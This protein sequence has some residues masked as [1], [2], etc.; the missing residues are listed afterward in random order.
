MTPRENTTLS[1]LYIWQNRGFFMG[2]LPDISEHR[3]GSAALCAVVATCLAK[4]KDD[5][6]ASAAELGHALA[7]L[8]LALGASGPGTQHGHGLAAEARH[9]VEEA[10]VVLQRHPSLAQRPARRELLVEAAAP[11]A[12][13]AL[14]PPFRLVLFAPPRHRRRP[15]AERR[16]RGARTL[17]LQVSLYD[18]AETGT[19]RFDR[20]QPRLV[21]GV[22]RTPKGFK[23]AFEAMKAGGWT[24]LDCDPDYGGQGL[25][26]LVSTAVSEIWS[27][28]NMAFALLSLI[29]I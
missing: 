25:P 16:E 12:H 28:A 3:L 14:G 29:H 6:F 27:A 19:L 5:R 2:R 23:D 26:A 18:R 1:K 4:R 17:G 24:A 13:R 9:L 7:G 10:V 20:P 8:D 21:N 11:G 15:V 22:V